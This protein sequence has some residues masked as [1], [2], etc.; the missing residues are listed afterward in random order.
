MAPL[1][2][3]RDFVGSMM[4]ATLALTVGTLFFSGCSEE[5][6]TVSAEE[7]LQRRKNKDDALE[8]MLNPT[9]APPKA[10]GKGK[11]KVDPFADKHL[12]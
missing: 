6:K 8:R 1:R 3:R 10:K 9:G 12:P 7:A 5:T 11:A 4:T 2:H